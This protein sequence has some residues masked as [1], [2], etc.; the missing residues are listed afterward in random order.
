MF[1]LILGAPLMIKICCFIVFFLSRQRHKAH[2]RSVAKTACRRGLAILFSSQLISANPPLTILSFC[3]STCC[4]IASFHDNETQ[5]IWEGQFSRRLPNQ[6]QAVARRKL[7]MLNNAR[8]IVDLRVPPQN[9]LEKLPGNRDGQW[10]IRIN[11]QWRV[12]FDWNEGTASRVRN[13]RL[14]LR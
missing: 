10:S 12:C 6:I 2:R 8:R 3:V 5:R 4:M 13:L 7:R 11:D 14:S 1:P 9:R